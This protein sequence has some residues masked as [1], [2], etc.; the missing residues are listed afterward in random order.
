MVDTLSLQTG[1]RVARIHIILAHG[2]ALLRA[3]APTCWMALIVALP[4]VATPTRW[5]AL[6]VALPRV[7]TPTRWMALIAALPR[8]ASSARWTA[9]QATRHCNA[10][11]T[12]GEASRSTASCTRP[13]LRLPSLLKGLGCG[14]AGA[15]SYTVA[16]KDRLA[17]HGTTCLRTTR[18]VSCIPSC[19]QGMLNL[20]R[21]QNISGI[22]L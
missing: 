7:A 6:I 1:G 16:N 17:R 4:R 14:Y 10:A 3:A 22:W 9:L 21:C 12:Y 8:A 2:V 19:W 20:R 13:R 18:R 15:A 5:M 11:S